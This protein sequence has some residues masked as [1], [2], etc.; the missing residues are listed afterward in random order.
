VKSIFTLLFIFA[1]IQANAAGQLADSTPGAP[2]KDVVI[3]FSCRATGTLANKEP[4][5]V[6]DGR[7]VEF[8]GLKNLDPCDIVSIEILKNA[9]AIAIYGSQA[10]N[11]VI[12]IRTKSSAAR[13]FIIRDI[14]DSS[15]IPAAS[16]SFVAKENSYETATDNNGILVTD[17]LKAGIQYEMSV[18]AVGYKP[19]SRPFVNTSSRV[20]TIFLERDIRMNDEVVITSTCCPRRWI[21]CGFVIKGAIVASALKKEESD[22]DKPLVYPNPVR[23]NNLFNLEFK[24]EQDGIARLSV[25]GLDGKMVMLQSEKIVTGVNHISV[26]TEMQWSAGIY[27]VQL[28]NEKG[29]V[30]RQEKLMVQ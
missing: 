17:N 14:S 6:I 10:I 9:E 25:T 20:E 19:I 21:S 8:N 29:T 30:I 16:I 24:N 15:I 18:S 11:G 4:I 5:V 23:R 3:R 28:R 7:Q 22:F 13:K 12:L 1:V 27:I 26:N 2:G